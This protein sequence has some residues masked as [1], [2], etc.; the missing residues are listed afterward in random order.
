MS[1][2]EKTPLL[3][4]YD[5]IKE[6]YEDEI[7]FFRLG[8]FYEMFYEDAEVASR[9]MEV[10]LTT[11]PVGKDHEIPMAGVPVHSVDSYV[12]DMLDE[13]HRVAICEQ[14]E[15]ASEAS[16]VVDREVIRV[17]TPGTLTEEDYL[18]S[19]KNNYLLSFCWEETETT[20]SA[21]R[22][23][24]AYVDLSTGEFEATQFEDDAE[25]NVLLSEINRLHPAEVVVPDRGEKDEF[26]EQITEFHE[27]IAVTG[28]PGW[29]F[30]FEEARRALE[31]QFA[32]EDLEEV[33]DQKNLTTAAGALVQYL[34]DT[35]KQTLAHLNRINT[36]QRDRFMILDAT[37]QRN[38][39]LA[40]SL[41]GQ[42]QAT[43]FNILDETETAMGSRRLRRWILQP[44]L[45]E[46]KINRRLNSVEWFHDN[47]PEI[48]AVREELGQLF[49]IQRIVG[50]VGSNRAN[51][52]DLKALGNSL[53]RI[54]EIKQILPDQEEFEQM[55]D[56]LHELEK[57]RDE[58]SRALVDN[59]PAK[60]SEGEIFQDGY[61]EQLDELREAMRGGKEWITN[62]QK[63]ERERTG[64]DSLKVGHNNVYG[65]Y[66][67]VTDANLDSVP[68]DYERKQT[69]A[70]SERYI[71]PELKEKEQ[72]IVG[73]EDKSMALEEELFLELREQVLDY[74]KQLQENAD[75]LA[76][77]DVIVSLASIA[78]E[79]GYVRPRVDWD[80]ELKLIQ[81]RHPVVEE[82]HDEEFVPNDLKLDSDR[83]LVVL[84]G[85][86]MSGKSTYIRQIALTSIMAQMGSFVPADE[87]HI[88][89]I[90]QVF[91]RVG[92]L[93]FLA[94]GQSTFMV[95][96]VET[97]DI[98]NNATERS[99]LILDEVGRGTSTY[100]GVAIAWSVVEYIARQINARTL[101]A[102]HYH[103]L[104]ELGNRLDNVFNMTVRAREWEDEIIFLRQVVEGHSDHSYGIQ[105]G[106]L[107]GLPPAVIDRAREIL[108]ELEEEKTHQALS[109]TDDTPAADQL[110]LFHPAYQV[111]RK[112]QDLEVED[113]TPLE[114]MNTLAQLQEN[115]QDI[116]SE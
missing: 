35:Q 5:R 96:M 34:G 104:T 24:V 53:E 63:E 77:L 75:V 61:S 47:G 82:I 84:T 22:V 80:E 103:E 60:I 46:R 92:A 52:R 112:L 49:D 9:V 2:D 72:M 50:K 15:E 58:L 105:V 40:E 28:R 43:L 115:S 38:L 6:Q 59:P 64:I 51:P 20:D 1:D 54:P 68:E 3:K 79:R 11:K 91:T 88:G 83:R 87:A 26:L 33:T 113:M 12:E 110:D 90:D 70:N 101:F 8:D 57:L 4:Q 106:K 95:E 86:N 97:A 30:E 107:A 55:K 31:N 32:A 114:A 48:P 37:S 7:L 76:D 10:T 17:I 116:D 23:G 94:G 89:M 45:S 78:R 29:Q 74:L 56:R 44:L 13:G 98:V 85:P 71:I 99:L 19:R 42:Q 25:I 27:R 108:Q 36:Y 102:T 100:D 62:L 67:E 81:A 73:A 109:K 16:G 93:D 66:I 21:Y 111:V 41:T 69:L 14:V 39:E 65:Y 18:D